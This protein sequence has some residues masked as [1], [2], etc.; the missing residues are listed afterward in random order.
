M[1]SQRMRLTYHRIINASA[2]SLRFRSAP[3][4]LR[5]DSKRG[6]WSYVVQ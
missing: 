3:L 4:C 6:A 5:L 1:R 2:G